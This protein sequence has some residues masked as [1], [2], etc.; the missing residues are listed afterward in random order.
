[1]KYLRTK[2]KLKK[3]WKRSEDTEDNIIINSSTNDQI[4]DYLENSKANQIAFNKLKNLGTSDWNPLTVEINSIGSATSAYKI[5]SEHIG[6]FDY[7][8]ISFF[9]PEILFRYSPSALEDESGS[10]PFLP[11]SLFFEKSILWEIKDLE[12]NEN[13]NMKDITLHAHIHSVSPDVEDN[14]FEF[15]FLLYY[16]NP[17]NFD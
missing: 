8:L 12:D 11:W 9:K 5:F 4:N 10:L 13:S 1:M 6:G 16:I 3:L 15:K 2:N 14:I 7:R 17:Q